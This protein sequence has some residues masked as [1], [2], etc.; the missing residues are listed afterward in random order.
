MGRGLQVFLDS[1]YHLGVDA[2]G[3]NLR[4]LV[5]RVKKYQRHRNENQEP[6]DRRIKRGLAKKY[7]S[8]SP[9]LWAASRRYCVE[10]THSYF[11][12]ILPSSDRVDTVVLTNE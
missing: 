1:R 7:N 6:R 2:G 11:Y 5:D 4:N 9:L 8:V 12:E 3:R 10:K